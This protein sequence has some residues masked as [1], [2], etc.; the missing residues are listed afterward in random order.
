MASEHITVET[1][2]VPA[3]RSGQTRSGYGN[4]IPNH[5]M[6]HLDGRWRRV[7]TT[8]WSNAGTSWVRWNGK[9]HIVR[10][11]GDEYTVDRNPWAWKP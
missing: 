4:A 5:T 2:H 6:V 3:P 10:C 11:F 9:R 1:K 8:I 7:Y